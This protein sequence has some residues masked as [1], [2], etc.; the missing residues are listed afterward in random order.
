MHAPAQQLPFAEAS[1]DGAL[2]LKS[3]HHVPRELMAQAFS[4]LAR[5]LRPGGWLYV[6]EPLYEGALNE[7][8]R[9]YNDEQAVRAAAQAAVD[10]AITG[11]RWQQ[12]AQ[13]RFDTPAK[14]ADFADFERRMMHPTFADRQ[15]DEA[16]RE[17][18]RRL[19]ERHMGPDGVHFTRPMHV[20]LLRLTRR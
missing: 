11:G 17:A 3:L 7:L 20:R 14:F 6:S 15:V 18:T 1:F 5:V 16:T 12:E 8:V 9:V 10:A 13:V 19:F 4:E 2:M